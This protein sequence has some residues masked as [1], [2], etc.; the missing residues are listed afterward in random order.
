MQRNKTIENLLPPLLT[1]ADDGQELS[2]V[3]SFY[4]SDLYMCYDRYVS[5]CSTRID[6]HGDIFHLLKEGEKWHNNPPENRD[7]CDSHWIH[8]PF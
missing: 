5:F 6:E 4:S 1:A 2:A 8:I 3:P 7:E